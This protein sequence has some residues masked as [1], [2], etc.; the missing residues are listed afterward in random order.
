MVAHKQSGQPARRRGRAGAPAPLAAVREI[1]A[2]LGGRV[3]DGVRTIRERA[4][5][6]A[7]EVT[8]TL[9]DEA[10]RWVDLQKEWAVGRV[11]GVADAVHK[12]AR[13]LRAANIDGVAGYVEGAAAGADE[14]AEYLQ[15]NDLRDMVDDAGDLAREYPTLFVAAMFAL[16]LAA[17]RVARAGREIGQAQA[18]TGEAGNRRGGG[19]H[20]A[21]R[22][23]RRGKGRA[24]G[25]KP[26]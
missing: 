24:A 4:A 18:P 8:E 5:D 11:T 9:R 15:D 13:V 19:G 21:G 16:G 2:E 23:G 20:D 6:K 7:G 14:V 1:S 12:A 25:R 17:G 26:E 3:R 10:G 22:R